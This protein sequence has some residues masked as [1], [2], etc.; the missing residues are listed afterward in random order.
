MKIAQTSESSSGKRWDRNVEILAMWK[1]SE[2]LSFVTPVMDLSADWV[3]L[4]L[5]DLLLFL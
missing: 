2:L 1:R 4:R 3:L 5:D